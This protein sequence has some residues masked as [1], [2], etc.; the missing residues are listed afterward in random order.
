MMHLR[1]VRD[2]LRTGQD[3]Y[4]CCSE[5]ASALHDDFVKALDNL[6]IAELPVDEPFG[7]RSVR[8]IR[9][10]VLTLRLPPWSTI[11]HTKRIMYTRKCNI[12]IIL[13]PAIKRIWRELQG[14]RL[15]DYQAT[16]SKGGSSAWEK[17][18]YS[19]ESMLSAIQKEKDDDGDDSVE[20]DSVEDDSV[21]DDSFFFSDST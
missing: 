16:S 21:E 20:D 6:G 10:A 17:T 4:G 12:H 9:D 11:H 13:Q 18:T 1:Q 14:L 8:Y 19:F 5:C 2:S 3:G 7:H 15:T